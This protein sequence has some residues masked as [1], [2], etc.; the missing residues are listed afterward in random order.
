MKKKKIKITCECGSELR[1]ADIAR[2]KKSQKHKVYEFL[3]E[4]ENSNINLVV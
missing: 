3:K 1:K 2:H 4:I